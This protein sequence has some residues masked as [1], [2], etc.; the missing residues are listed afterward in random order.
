MASVGL[1]MNTMEDCKEYE[2]LQPFYVIEHDHADLCLK[3]YS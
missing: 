2:G 3:T 1:G